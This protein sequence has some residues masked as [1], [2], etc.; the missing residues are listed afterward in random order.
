MQPWVSKSALRSPPEVGTLVGTDP[1]STEPRR[2]TLSCMS[3][4]APNRREA[5]DGR[6]PASEMLSGVAAGDEQA[7]EQLLEHVYDELRGIARARLAGERQGH[8]LQATALVHE[9]WIRLFGSTG[10]GFENRAHFFGA[11]GEAM[12]RILVD[13]AR[14]RLAA[15]RGA[16]KAPDPLPEG[17]LLRVSKDPAEILSVDEALLRMEDRQPRAATIVRL[18]F[19]AGLELKEIA[20]ALDLSTRTVE[21]EWA[22]ARA[23]LYRDLG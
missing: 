2:C 23:L 11:A 14:R 3:D 19:F 21:R 8:S 17:G 10:A 22:Y 15:K 18:R 9:A 1:P 5:Q 16:G 12:R 13:H 7:A 6:G 4:D 20:E